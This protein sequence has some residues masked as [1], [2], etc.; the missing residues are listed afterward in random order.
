[1]TAGGEHLRK[2]GGGNGAKMPKKDT[3]SEKLPD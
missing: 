1:V 2:A 3:T